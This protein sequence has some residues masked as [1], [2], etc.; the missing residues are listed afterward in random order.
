ME[1]IENIASALSECT[2]TDIHLVAFT[3]AEHRQLYS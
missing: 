1:G 2:V 3:E